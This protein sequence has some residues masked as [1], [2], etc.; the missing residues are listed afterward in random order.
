[1]PNT[2]K[3]RK[4]AIKKSYDTGMGEVQRILFSTQSTSAQKKAAKKSLDNLTAM[5]LAYTVST[6]EG[7]T[8]LLAG[9]IVEL[10]D[11]IAKVETRPPYTE[12]VTKLSGILNNARRL[13]NSEVAA[14]VCDSQV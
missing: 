12:A 7:R 8:S 11:V 1:M 10:S 3:T 13:F 5:L 14:L 6:V 4:A 2:D 9:L